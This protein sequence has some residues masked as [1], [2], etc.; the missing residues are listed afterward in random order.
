MDAKINAEL[1]KPFPQ[2]VLGTVKKGGASLTYVPVAE[3]I[4]RLNL[5]LG[6]ENWSETFSHTAR[7]PENPDWIISEVML[8]A[9]INGVTSTKVGYGGAKIKVYSS[10]K[11]ANAGQP[12]DLGDDYKSAH[13]DAFKKAAQQFGIGLEL[14]RDESALDREEHARRM[15]SLEADAE[16][17]PLADPEVIEAIRAGI[18]GLDVDARKKFSGWWKSNIPFGLTSGKVTQEQAERALAEIG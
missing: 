4:A 15:M 18:D 16:G 14:A 6:T 10:G 12:T 8:S 13:S 5:V 17:K 11:G 9:T 7:D 1:S 3:V 2:D